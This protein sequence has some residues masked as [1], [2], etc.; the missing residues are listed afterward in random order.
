MQLVAARV[1][2]QAAPMAT[3]NRMRRPRTSLAWLLASIAFRV[4]RLGWLYCKLG[5]LLAL[6][7]ILL[8]AQGPV[9]R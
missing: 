3:L 6:R 2:P 8:L 5:A 9:S 4:L 1:L 7:F